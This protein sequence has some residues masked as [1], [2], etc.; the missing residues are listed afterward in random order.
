MIIE[1]HVGLFQ[2]TPAFAR[3]E[4]GITRPGSN[5]MDRFHTAASRTGVE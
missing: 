2:D 5:Q 4:I 1:H 3:D